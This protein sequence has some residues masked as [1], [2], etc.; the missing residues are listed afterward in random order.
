[1]SAHPH[2]GDAT[3][4]FEREEG[5]RRQHDDRGHWLESHD[6]VRVKLAAGALALVSRRLVPGEVKRGSHDE[7]RRSQ[8]P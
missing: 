8:Q 4:R 2:T 7:K 1:M 5:S 3:E 6:R